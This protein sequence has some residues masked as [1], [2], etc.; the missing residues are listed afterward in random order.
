MIYMASRTMLGLP[1]GGLEVTME[2]EEERDSVWPPAVA[3]VPPP[4]MPGGKGRLAWASAW[5]GGIGLSFWLSA[6]AS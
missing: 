4:A 6:T 2:A 5:V 1:I 3:L